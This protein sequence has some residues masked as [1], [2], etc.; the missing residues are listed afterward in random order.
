M[1]A[2][3]EIED[4]LEAATRLRKVGAYDRA[5]E[6]LSAAQEIDP[7]YAEAYA[8]LCLVYRDQ[9]RSFKALE[10]INEALR[11]KPD[12]SHYHFIK[13]SILLLA[14]DMAEAEASLRR[15]IAMRPDDEDYYVTLSYALVFQKRF[16]EAESVARQAIQLAPNSADAHVAVGNVLEFQKRPKE[17]LQH[18]NEAI[19]LGPEDELSHLA[20]GQHF[21][22]WPTSEESDA[23]AQQHLREVLRQSPE[24]KDAQ[25]A[26]KKAQQ[27]ALS[28]DGKTG[29]AWPP[30]VLFCCSWVAHIGT[31]AIG[32]LFGLIFVLNWRRLG[33]PD[34]QLQTGAVVLALFLFPIVT[35]GFGLQPPGGEPLYF[36][37]PPQNWF[38]LLRSALLLWLAWLQLPQFFAHEKRGSPVAPSRQPILFALLFS[39]LGMLVLT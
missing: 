18:F 1:N 29:A 33:R 22:H 36:L 32:S 26:L 15:A 17:A 21:S 19:R 3:R 4:R 28:P 7:N 35:G 5:L 6:Q 34:K 23:L 16:D 24:N 30:L 13:G 12:N 20:L 38:N 2:H 8:E 10:A 31:G 25:K 37:A 14:D 9:E 11:L 27:L 39:L